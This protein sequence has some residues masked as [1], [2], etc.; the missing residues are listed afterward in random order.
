LSA[1]ACSGTARLLTRL[2][3][4]DSPVR[5][6]ALDLDDTGSTIDVAVFEREQL[7]GSKPSRSG[8]QNHRPMG[9]PEVLCERP[10]LLP[11]VERALFAAAPS[12]IRHAFGG[13]VVDQLPG[14]RSI[15][16]LPQRLGRFEAVP[17]R[18]DEPPCGDLV[19]RELSETHLAKRGGR[20]PEQP[21]KLRDRD[22]FTLVRAQVL[23]DPLGERQRLG[24]ATGHEPSQLVLK[25]PLRLGLSAEPAHLP[26]RRTT[27]CDPIPVRPQRLTV[28]ARRLQLEHLALLDHDHDLL[29]TT[30]RSRSLSPLRASRS[31]TTSLTQR[32]SSG[33][34]ESASRK[35][36]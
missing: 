1:I 17:F 9:P 14:D 26:S 2:R 12:R 4:L 24:T 20:L 29:D 21:A 23:L 8:E 35:C 18:N 34:S 10:D 22:A 36:G 28:H 6:G 27:T 33:D 31:L 30:T 13:V 25:R 15:Q 3:V 19:R 32:A 11:G 7:G 16:H 5:I